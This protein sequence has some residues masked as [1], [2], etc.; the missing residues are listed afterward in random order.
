M[1]GR[2]RSLCGI[3]EPPPPIRPFP[4][5][6]RPSSEPRLPSDAKSSKRWRYFPALCNLRSLTL[7][8]TNI[9]HICNQTLHTCFSVLRQT[10]TELSLVGF[11]TSFSTLMTL[12]GYF[13]NITTLR[14]SLF[15]LVPDERPAIPLPQPLRGKLCIWGFYAASLPGLADWLAKLDPECDELVIESAFAVGTEALERV[16]RSSAGTIKYLR[17][18]TPLQRKHSYTPSSFRF[19]TQR[20]ASQAERLLLVSFS[21]CESWNYS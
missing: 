10:L 11:T 4:P 19:L 7:C 12:V 3:Q 2:R 6:L 5:A 15:M 8:N 13:P 20:L 1:D 18:M 14:M 17:L 21:N 9:G 16:L